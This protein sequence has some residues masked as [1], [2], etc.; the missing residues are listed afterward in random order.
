MFKYFSLSHIIVAYS[1]SNSR[2]T[3][4][5]SCVTCRDASVQ[6]ISTFGIVCIIHACV[7]GLVSYATAHAATLPTATAS[8][9]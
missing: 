8:G 7:G 3:F 9:G 6:L 5:F 4:F 1:S 2:E